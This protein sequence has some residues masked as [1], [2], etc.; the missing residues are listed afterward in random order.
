MPN[1]LRC[2]A[3][4]EYYAGEYGGSVIEPKLF[5]RCATW[6]SRLVDRLT[7]GRVEKIN[8]SAMPDF[9]KDAVCAAAE[10]YSSKIKQTENDI[11]SENNDG[12]SVSYKTAKSNA[13]MIDEAKNIISTYLSNTG[14]TY[15]GTMRS[16]EA[17]MY[18]EV[19]DD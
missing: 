4:Y 8:D 10:I 9:V 7:F 3:S 13:D 6:A 1:T 17:I 19:Y 15:R 12:Y 16:I 11:Q 2:Y 5:L 14:L 18:D